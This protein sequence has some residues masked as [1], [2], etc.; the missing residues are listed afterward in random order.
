MTIED[1]EPAY[2]RIASLVRRYGWTV[3]DVKQEAWLVLSRLA[4]HPNWPRVSDPRRYAMKTLARHCLRT[5]RGF[6]EQL[7]DDPFL[8]VES[9]DDI[10]RVELNDLV[11]SA[12]GE[13]RDYLTLR[14]IEGKTW[15][16]T[17]A[18]MGGIS[19]D[20]LAQFRHATADWLLAQLEGR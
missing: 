6:Y 19:N 2:G 14:V 3:D 16:Q 11:A 7:G 15:D 8:L 20:R 12:P 13:C 18:A 17:R 5:A 10:A 4:G 1:L 9:Y